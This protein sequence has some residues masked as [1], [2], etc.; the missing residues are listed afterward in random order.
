MDSSDEEL[1]NAA[2]S[3]SRSIINT[4]SNLNEADLNEAIKQT[5]NLVQ[6]PIKERDC[7]KYLMKDISVKIIRLSNKQ[8]MNEQTNTHL[9][10]NK[11]KTETWNVEIWKVR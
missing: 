2:P 6:D 4:S 11:K 7:N 1:F 8:I 3:Y 5:N 9:V 10:K